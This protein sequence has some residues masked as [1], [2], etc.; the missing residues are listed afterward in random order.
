M[1]LIAQQDTIVNIKYIFKGVIKLNNKV[2]ILGAGPGNPELLT[3]K[4]K[5][6]IEQS[7]VIIYDRLVSDGVLMLAKPEAEFI[8][9]GKKPNLHTMPQEEINH[10]I[11]LKALEGKTVA[12]VKG[13]DPFLFGRGGE[14]VEELIKYNIK[15]EIVPGITSAIAVPEYAGIPVTHRDYTSSVHIITGHEKNEKINGINYKKFSLLDETLIFL[16]SISNLNYIT[17]ELIDGGKSPDTPVAV[18]QNGTT[19]RQRQI[20]GRLDNIYDLVKKNNITSPAITVVGKVA[21]LG[22]KL[23][24]FDQK[25]LSGQKILVT[26]ART[27]ASILADKLEQQGAEV[28]QCPM[29]RIMPLDEYTQMDNELSSIEKYQWI[30]FTSINGVEHFFERMKKCKIDIRKI[31]AKIA[32]IGYETKKILEAK[33]FIVDYMPTIYTSEELAKGLKSLIAYGDNILLS[34][35]DIADKKIVQVLKASGAICTDLAVYKTI[36]D[37]R[38]KVK[39]ITLLKEESLDYIT[40]ASSATVENFIKLLGTENKKLLDNIK[41]VC[42]G[43]VTAKKAE[44]S[45]L[46][47]I[48]ISKIHTI[49]GMIE[50]IIKNI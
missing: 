14:E 15:Y 26:R 40:F 18:I 21:E 38:Y 34:R 47:N 3:I 50:T 16:M 9:V 20:Y 19:N 41:I 49:D 31:K 22:K 27:Q 2:Y 45:G 48:F 43:F 7:D 5:K 39:L 4:A 12:R 23:A 17:K 37:E 6:C 28:F 1:Q 30:V 42:I 32:V 8:Y 13:G 35:A 10:L 46:K 36:I 24:W 33:G 29:I 44:Q 11:V 25:I